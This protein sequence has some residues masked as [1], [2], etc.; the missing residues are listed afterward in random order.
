VYGGV[1]PVVVAVQVNAF[2]EVWPVPQLT[3]FVSDWALTT[4]VAEP[5]PVTVLASLAVLLME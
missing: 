2:P 5:V 3:E 1:P 4:A